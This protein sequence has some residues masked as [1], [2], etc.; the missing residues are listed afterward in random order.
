MHVCAKTNSYFIIFLSSTFSSNAKHTFIS[1]VYLWLIVRIPRIPYDL[2]F[3]WPATL[4][5]TFMRL[6]LQ[7]CCILWYPAILLLVGL[8]GWLSWLEFSSGGRDWLGAS[9]GPSVD[10]SKESSGA[11]GD[12]GEPSDQEQH[13]LLPLKFHL[14]DIHH[15]VQHRTQ[16][17]WWMRRLTNLSLINQFLTVKRPS[18]FF[19]GFKWTTKCE[20]RG[21]SWILY[22]WL[23]S[24]FFTR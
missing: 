10:M 23:L 22:T 18:Y 16:G 2:R 19:K 9:S 6:G 17:Y 21:V 13:H 15:P 24:I 14:Y 12:W 8:S 20:E 4:S 1:G 5:H 3:L 11:S 7:G